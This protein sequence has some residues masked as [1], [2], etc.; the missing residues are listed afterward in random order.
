MLI[1]KEDKA[2]EAIKEEATMKET[3][4]LTSEFCSQV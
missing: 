3:C 1:S 4:N 2:E